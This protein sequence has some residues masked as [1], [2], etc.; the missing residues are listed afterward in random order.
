MY[1]IWTSNSHRKI[2]VN[3]TEMDAV[4]ETHFLG[5]INDNKSQKISRV[6]RNAKISLQLF[7]VCELHSTNVDR[8]KFFLYPFC[9]LRV[10]RHQNSIWDEIFVNVLGHISNAELPTN[11][12]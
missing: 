4:L 8:P 11:G 6:S 3:E 9:F 5:V 2:K 1:H 10:L 7:Y 12:R